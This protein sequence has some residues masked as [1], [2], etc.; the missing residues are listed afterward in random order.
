MAAIWEKKGKK[1]HHHHWSGLPRFSLSLTNPQHHLGITTNSPLQ[2]LEF[3]RKRSFLAWFVQEILAKPWQQFEKKR[4]KRVYLSNS[5]MW[6][7]RRVKMY[8]GL[9][10]CTMSHTWWVKLNYTIVGM[11][12]ALWGFLAQRSLGPSIC[13]CHGFLLAVMYNHRGLEQ[14]QACEDLSPLFNDKTSLKMRTWCIHK[15]HW[16]KWRNGDPSDSFGR[17]QIEFCKTT[18]KEKRIN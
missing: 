7:R 2:E 3:E 15:R 6:P 10:A 11:L 12:C 1:G 16:T 14:F 18:T 5:P 9:V 8:W 13:L 17:Y 4:A